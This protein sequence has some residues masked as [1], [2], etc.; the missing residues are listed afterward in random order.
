VLSSP[1]SRKI[2]TELPMEIVIRH[3]E[4]DDYEA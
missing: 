1:Y 4:P 2:S 3:A